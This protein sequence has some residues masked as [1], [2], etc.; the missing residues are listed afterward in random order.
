MDKVTKPTRVTL[1]DLSPGDLVVVNMVHSG[2][3]RVR[4]TGLV[5]S[6][7]RASGILA[8]G[9]EAE[10]WRGPGF[11]GLLSDEEDW[12]NVNGTEAVFTAR[13]L[14]GRVVEEAQR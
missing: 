13:E 6:C 12:E 5:E 2:T 9:P 14:V 8:E 10:D 1:E 3:H 4:V 7:E 11:T